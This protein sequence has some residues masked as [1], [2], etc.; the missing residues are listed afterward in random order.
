M[1]APEVWLRGPIPGVP[2]L[3]QPV[4]HSLMQCREELTAA[5][6]GLTPEQLWHRP[7]GAA[8]IGFHARHAA[9]S[10]D[11]LFTYARAEALS[12]AQLAALAAEDTPDDAEDAAASLV[13]A[14]GAAVESRGASGRAAGW[15]SGGR[16]STC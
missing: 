3:A 5:L 11:R 12:A 16:S 7:N 1:S 6:A 2:P 9:G 4:A 10:I 15:S 13:A 8:S 14:F